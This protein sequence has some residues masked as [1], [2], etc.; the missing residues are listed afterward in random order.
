MDLNS[1]IFYLNKIAPIA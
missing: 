1:Q